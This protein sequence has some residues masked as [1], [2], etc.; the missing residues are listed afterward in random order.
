MQQSAD[1]LRAERAQM[2]NQ[3]KEI[4]SQRDEVR[5]EKT[6]ALSK[7][8]AVSSMESAINRKQKELE[9]LTRQRIDIQAERRKIREKNDLLVEKLLKAVAVVNERLMTHKECTTKRE[10]AKKKLR[11]FDD[12]TGNVDDKIDEVKRNIRELEYALDNAKRDSHAYETRMI[13]KRRE[14]LDLT[15]NIDQSAKNFPYK[16]KF[17]KL[18]QTVEELEDK[19][20]EMQGRIECIRGVDPAI[21]EEYERRKETIERLN[22]DLHN[23]QARAM[24]LENELKNL[25]QTWYPQITSVVNSINENFSNF[26]AKMGFVG[27]VEL[28]HKEERDYADYG[29]VIRVQ[30]RD[31]EKLQALNRHIQSGGERAVAIAVYTLSLQHLTT[32]PFRCVDEINQV[33]LFQI[34]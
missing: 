9:N 23:E 29:I 7:T 30:Y 27:E 25:H 1:N 8:R 28:V 31:S 4:E 6:E 16:K 2:E 17:E 33:N 21:V 3:M 5:A 34:S 11:V 20:L 19:I 15:D 32:V 13:S 22:D 24:A 10:L 14:A 26:F 12:S 18:P